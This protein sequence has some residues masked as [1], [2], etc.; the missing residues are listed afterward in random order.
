M[1]WLLRQ[2]LR[3]CD[4]NGRPLAADN[5][6]VFGEAI[7]ISNDLAAFAEP[8]P[9]PTD[10]AI[11]AN[12]LPNM[13]YFSQED[14]DR[15]IG[16]MLYLL[17]DLAPNAVGTP[18]P[19]LAG[20]LQQLLGYD[21]A[22]Y[23]DLAMACA[24]KGLLGDYSNPATFQV[25]TIGPLDFATTSIPIDTAAQYLGANGSDEQDLATR[26]DACQNLSDMTPVRERPFVKYQERF[27]PLDTAFIL[28]KA[29]SGIFWT[30][31]KN[32]PDGERA[33]L[34]SQWGDLFERYVNKLLAGGLG[35]HSRVI[36]AP[37][38]PNGDQACDGV[39]AEPDNMIFLEYKASTI[40]STI[41]YAD[42]PEHLGSMLEERFVIG[43]G[44]ARKGLSQLH[45]AIT[46]F[47]NGEVLIHPDGTAVE[48][49]SSGK[50]MP[51]L[52]HLDNALRTVAV[53]HYFIE[54]FKQLGRFKGHTITP[55]TTLPVTELEELE[56]HL[57]EQPLSVFLESFLGLVRSDKTAVFIT[58]ILP[59][60]RGKSRTKGATLRRFGEYLD[61]ME[62]RLF[63][64]QFAPRG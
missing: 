2:A 51:V 33:I 61:A 24:M 44:A 31:L 23:C 1:L 15:D 53:P 57:G 58:R 49:R 48:A 26:F 35:K 14:Y 29:G 50:I 20:R 46:R 45:R 43:Q 30:A 16:R 36:P 12:M 27:L 22:E 21:V 52:V 19:G 63:P 11:A 37:R 47:I 3:Y 17:T 34:L 38:F 60:L 41:R 64:E 4:P 42:N 9:L 62:R 25:N 28:D 8:K 18:F 56:G 55:V 6:G 10:L 5:I 39:I 13:E 32:A 40:S 7:L 59:A 54:R